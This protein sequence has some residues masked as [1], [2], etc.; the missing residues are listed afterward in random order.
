MALPKT[1][2][3]MSAEHKAKLGLAHLG[4]VHSQDTRDKMGSPGD[5][6]PAWRGGVTYS[7]EY[8]NWQKNKRN[9]VL[10][11]I[12]EEGL[13]HTFGEWEDLKAQYGY[14]CPCCGASEPDSPL[15]I[16]HITPLSRGG[17]DI[18]ENIQ[19]L[20]LPCNMKK[21]TKVIKY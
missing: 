13:S 5:T 2:R 9:R 19:P 18:I 15:T 14:T 1:K 10:K 17:S 4:K 3:K 7:Q 11:R 6:N 21:H 12:K 20:C 16:D 8:V